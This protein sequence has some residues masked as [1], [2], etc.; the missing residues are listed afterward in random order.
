V[1]F[2]L[3]PQ[4]QDLVE[5]ATAAG[6]EWREFAGKWDEENE[7]PFAEVTARMRELGLLGLLM[8]K[9]L[10]GAD[11]T[12]LDYALVIEALM[13]TSTIWITAE[14]TFLATG[15]GAMMCMMSPNVAVRE[16][17]LRAIVAGEHGVAISISEP[18]FGSDMTSLGTTAVL[19]GDEWV[20]TGEKKWITGAIVNS[21]YATFVRFDG[22]PG[23]K[24][25]GAIMVER[26]T[27]GF[28]MQRG[29]T[30]VGSR[31]VP[32][33]DLQYNK[34]RV[35]K[36]NLLFGPGDFGVLMRAFNIERL[37]NTACSLGSAEA[38]FDEALEYTKNRRQF[39]RKLIEFQSVYHDLADMWAQIESARYL[40]YK[41]AAS[42]RDGKLPE[43]MDVSIAKYV[44]NNVLADV[45]TRCVLLQGAHGTTTASFAQR[46]HRDSLVN[47]VA[48]GSVQI[49]LNV[50]AG[51]LV[52]D[53]KF[54][55][56][57]DTVPASQA[58]ASQAPGSQAPAG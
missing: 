43:P 15:P 44:S 32:H 12:A 55:Q 22:I 49:L 57:P 17:Y 52:P 14:P 40:M 19:D 31:G 8:P 6:L 13:R 10:G 20:I 28:E 25:I 23:A 56:R 9:E 42:A 50:I 27:P 47:K 46:I 4:Q 39:G 34:V 7:A 1:D 41:A 18:E 5:R 2:A 54:P 51:Q 30:F 35:P 45:S 48:G 53:Q 3:S 33:G 36:E 38:A 29:P 11:L 21:L 58:P 37:H 26:G 16:K 24:G